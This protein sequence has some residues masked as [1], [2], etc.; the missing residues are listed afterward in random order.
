M[1]SE[2]GMG[3]EGVGREVWGGITDREAV[4]ISGG[5]RDGVGYQEGVD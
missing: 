3:L 4:G 1:G 2:G 5:G